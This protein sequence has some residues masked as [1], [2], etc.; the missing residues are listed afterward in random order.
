MS[1]GGKSFVQGVATRVDNATDALVIGFVLGPAMVPFYSVPANLVNYLRTLGW[2]LSHA[3]MP[4]FSRLDAMAE[5]DR[6]REIYLTASKFVVGLLL[7]ISAGILVVGSPFLTLWIG[8]EYGEKSQWV[9]FYLVAFCILPLLNPFAS[10]YLTAI[11]QH[12]IFARLMPIGAA[13]NLILSL[14]LVHTHG[15]EGVAF[16]SLIPTIVLVPV[17]L[18]C[19]CRNLG[20]SMLDYVRRCLLPVLIPTASLGVTAVV[21]RMVTSLDSYGDIVLT[22]VGGGLVWLPCF[23]FMALSPQDRASFLKLFRSKLAGG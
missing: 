1:F 6:T 13:A 5:F 21:I 9:F 22:A 16:A 2:T 18:K 19:V 14:I 7:P 10:R 11:N 20:I 8:P 15:I 4:L 3:F 23:W 12:G 17:Y